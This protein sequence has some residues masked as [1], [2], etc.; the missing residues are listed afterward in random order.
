MFV[1]R[2]KLTEDFICSETPTATVIY[3]YPYAGASSYSSAYTE[4]L[5]Y[6]DAYEQN[7]SV[8]PV[9]DKVYKRIAVNTLF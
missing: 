7:M 2:L 3:N 8:I 6:M 5:M 1:E 9:S 4:Y